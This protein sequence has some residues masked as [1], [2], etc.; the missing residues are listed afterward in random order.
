M[1]HF[2]AYNRG[3]VADGVAATVATT[4]VSQHRADG[5]IPAALQEFVQQVQQSAAAPGTRAR[6]PGQ[7]TVR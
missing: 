5:D 1:K 6:S 4:V 3:V 7:S 2:G